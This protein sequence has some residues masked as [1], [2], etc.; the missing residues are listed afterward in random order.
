MIDENSEARFCMT[1]SAVQNNTRARFG[2]KRSAIRYAVIE[3]GDLR[4][5]LFCDG[6]ENLAAKRYR[7]S[8]KK[9]LINTDID[10]D[11]A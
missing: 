10:R 2:I 9:K 5:S 1:Q 4:G 8:A 11:K 6:G 3:E 7:E